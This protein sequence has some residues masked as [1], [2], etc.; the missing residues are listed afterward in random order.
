MAPKSGE[1]GLPQAMFGMDQMIAVHRR[2]LEALMTASRVMAEGMQQCAERQFHLA[3]ETAGEM[4]S[5]MGAPAVDRKGEL[6]LTGQMER[7]RTTYER[8]LEQMKE[9]QEIFMKAHAEAMQVLYGS[10]TDSVLETGQTAERAHKAMQEAVKEVEA[11]VAEMTHAVEAAG[12]AAVE[13][14][15]EAAETA[16]KS[17]AKTASTLGRAVEDNGPANAGTRRPARR[18]SGN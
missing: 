6:D 5:G 9:I 15:A 13:P 12:K 1:R 7:V 3:R 8:L 16:A 11:R 18:S 14:L 17:A 10:F 4:L 2:N